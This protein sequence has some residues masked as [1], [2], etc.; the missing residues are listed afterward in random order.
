MAIQKVTLAD[1]PNDYIVLDFETT[2]LN[3]ACEAIIQI[4]AIRIRDRKRVAEF[5]TYVNPRKPLTPFIK[6]HTGLSDRKLKNAPFIEQVLPKLLEFIA[7]DMIVCHNAQF[8]ISF[9]EAAYKNVVGENKHFHSRCTLEI[10][11]ELSPNMRAHKLAYL[12][13]KYGFTNNGREHDALYDCKCTHDLYEHQRQRVKAK[14]KKAAETKIANEALKTRAKFLGRTIKEQREREK[15]ARYVLH[16]E[17]FISGVVNLHKAIERAASGESVF[18]KVDLNLYDFTLIKPKDF[19]KPGLWLVTSI[20]FII[21]PIWLLNLGI[22]FWEDLELFLYFILISSVCGFIGSLFW[23]LAVNSFNK[24]VESEPKQ[25]RS[26]AQQETA[27]VAVIA[28]DNKSDKNKKIIQMIITIIVIL[29]ISAIIA[30][31]YIIDSK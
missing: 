8:D 14:E 28:G 19:V 31:P 11:R 7:D 23:M 24:K 30:V 3:A 20:V 15:W 25:E 16:E 18:S 22:E 17:E 10:N 13:E 2:G 1:F 26:L 12:T 9:L 29:I 21:V 4:G 6:S 5:N 27:D